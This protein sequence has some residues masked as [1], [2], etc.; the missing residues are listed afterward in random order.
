MLRPWMTT[1]VTIKRL[2]RKYAGSEKAATQARTSR[3]RTIQDRLPS[4]AEGGTRPMLGKEVF[5]KVW[6]RTLGFSPTSLREGMSP[7]SQGVACLDWAGGE[8]FIYF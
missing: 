8:A 4:P 2:A 6:E 1:A 7:P 5:T 3:C